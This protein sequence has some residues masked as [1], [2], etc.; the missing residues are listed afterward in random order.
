LFENIYF[1]YLTIENIEKF[2]SK[3]SFSNFTSKVFD[4]LSFVFKSSK[5]S[6]PSNCYLSK[7]EIESNNIFSLKSE[8]ESLKSEFSKVQPQLASIQSEFTHFKNIPKPIELF[9][10]LRS[11]FNNQSPRE[12]GIVNVTA[13]SCKSQIT[14]P[15]IF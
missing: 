12:A 11:Q 1:E 7:I 3:Y 13:S 2:I 5:R 9:K 4:S 10:Y 14:Y 6:L 8:I 15:K